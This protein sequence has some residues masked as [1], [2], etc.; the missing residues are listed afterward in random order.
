MIKMENY[1][2]D[3][4]IY[5]DYGEHTW[6]QERYLVHGYD[7]VLWT[8]DIEQAIGYLKR[9]LERLKDREND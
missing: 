1:K 5:E 6:A 9:E 4:E 2:L 8:S 7:D 3:I